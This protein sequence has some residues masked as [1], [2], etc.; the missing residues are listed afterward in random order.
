M[1]YEGFAYVYD[2]LMK[3]APYED[4]VAFVRRHVKDGA[5]LAD[6]GCGTGSATIRLAEHYETIGLDLSES[7]LEVAQEKALE[8]GIMLPLWQ[9][10]MRELEL[11]HPV[12]AVTILCDSLCYLEDE[13]DVIDT[14]EAVYEQLKPGGMFIFDVHSP[15]K[16]QTLF[17]QKTYASNGEDCSYIWFA[18][19]GEAPLSVVHDLTFFVALEDGTYDRVEETHEQRTYE[20]GQYMQWLIGAGFHVKSV[21]ADFTDQAPGPNAERIFFVAQK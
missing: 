10:D 15:N 3:D 9:Q 11:P 17:N 8:A 4:W 7:M 6:V 5:S 14:F 18:D 12:D 1:A 2:E 21:T 20:S 16:M 19:P 13:A